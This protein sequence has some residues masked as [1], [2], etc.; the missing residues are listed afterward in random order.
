MPKFWNFKKLNNLLFRFL[1]EFL[2]DWDGEQFFD[3]I[4]GL[5]KVCQITEFKEIYDT[6]LSQVEQH[7]HVYTLID[8]VIFIKQGRGLFSCSS[9]IKSFKAVPRI[10]FI[11]T[12]T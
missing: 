8:K 11:W 3:E 2:I 9:I 4:L 1:H 5:I 10:H 6:I 7:F 12:W